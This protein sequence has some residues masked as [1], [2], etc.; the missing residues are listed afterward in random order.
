MITHRIVIVLKVSVVGQQAGGASVFDAPTQPSTM[1]PAPPSTGSYGY[2]GSAAAPPKPASYPGNLPTTTT[3]TTPSSYGAP[4][5]SRPVNV[6][7]HAG[8]YAA[9]GPGPMGPVIPISG[10]NPYQNRWTIKAR[11][12]SKSDMRSWSNA[13]G[14]GT[15][16][17][18]DLLDSEGSAIRA[19]FFKEACEKFYGQLAEGRV[20]LPLPPSVHSHRQ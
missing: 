7:D 15:L 20:R 3:T 9:G 16:F 13:K 2:G 17:S 4:P 12:T 10:L 1:K 14:E 18:I 6:M 19:T 5:Q 11:I 8:A